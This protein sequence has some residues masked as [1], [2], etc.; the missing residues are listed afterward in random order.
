M[1]VITYFNC[2]AYILNDKN[3]IIR[4]IV[5][6]FNFLISRNMSL[7]TMK[8]IAL[9]TPLRE[10]SI[11]SNDVVYFE[12]TPLA[13]ASLTS[14]SPMVYVPLV[15]QRVRNVTWTGFWIFFI[16][17]LTVYISFSFWISLSIFSL[18][19]PSVNYKICL[20]KS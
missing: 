9:S 18:V 6:H 13:T 11:R 1:L 4:I 17:V 14:V 10:Y 7:C 16:F 2:I 20:H 5:Q 8:W 15:P 19:V 3:E 12:V